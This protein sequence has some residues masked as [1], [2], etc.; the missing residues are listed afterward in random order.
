MTAL[1]VLTPLR[2][3]DQ[4]FDAAHPAVMAIVNRTPDSFYSP[5]RFSDIDEA[6]ARVDCVVADGADVVDV[7]GVRAGQ[8]GPW[9]DADEEI[10]RVRPLLQEIRRRHPD[11]LLSLDTWRSEVAKACDG[12]IDLV[13]DTWQG[14][15]PALVAAAAQQGTAYVVS[16]TGGLPPRTDPIDV[17]YGD[18][19]DEAVLTAVR[20]RLEQGAATALRAGLG[21]EQVLLDPTLD[22]GKNTEHSLALLRHT[23]ELTTL[24][25]PLMMAISR[26]DFVGETLGLPAAE[27]LEGSLGA[28]AIAAWFGAVLFRTHDVQATRRVVDMVASIRGDRPPLVHERGC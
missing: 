19:S 3:R 5:A 24:G 4:V 18:D 23:G 14:N 6:L 7:G 2:L 11:V 25:F 9:V 28:T 21:P 16:H 22:F 17:H 27:R 13:N 26:K 1:G 8:Q 15:D 10:D 20:D 12:L